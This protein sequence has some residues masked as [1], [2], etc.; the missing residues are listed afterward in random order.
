MLSDKT[1]NKRLYC[2]M[3]CYFTI[4][5]MYQNVYLGYLRVREGRCQKWTCTVSWGYPN[6]HVEQGNILCTQNGGVQNT[7]F[8]NKH[9]NKWGI[10]GCRKGWLRAGNHVTRTPNDI[11]SLIP[12]LV[13][14]EGQ[15]ID[16]GYTPVLTEIPILTILAIMGIIGHM[17]HTWQIWVFT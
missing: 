8:H 17:D 14:S 5:S 4:N 3:P 6:P 2:H 11:Y 10:L 15:R 13:V 1:I 12:P 9:H 16:S 7:R